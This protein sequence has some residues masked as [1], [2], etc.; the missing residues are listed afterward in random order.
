MEAAPFPPLV[1]KQR[2]NPHPQSRTEQNVIALTLMTTA[3]TIVAVVTSGNVNFQG[4]KS[5]CYL[6]DFEI[7]LPV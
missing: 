6:D 4:N 7:K 3:E 2:V 5:K 1:L